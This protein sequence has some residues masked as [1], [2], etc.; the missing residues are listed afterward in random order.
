MGLTDLLTTCQ[1]EETLRQVP[2]AGTLTALVVT[3][4]WAGVACKACRHGNSDDCT[5]GLCSWYC[6]A[7]DKMARR[8]L[9]RLRFVGASV[10]IESAS[11][12]MIFHNISG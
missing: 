6:S 5:T 2:A 9:M 12:R 1:Q 3:G 8:F 7:Q 11:L 10:D 4:F